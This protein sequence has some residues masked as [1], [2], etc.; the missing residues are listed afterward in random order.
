MKTRTFT[1]FMIVSLF[2]FAK[3]VAENTATTYRVTIGYDHP[4]LY[5]CPN[6]ILT[7]TCNF[8]PGLNHNPTCE[9][10]VMNGKFEDGTTKKIGTNLFKV[11]VIWSD[12]SEAVGTIKVKVVS[13][14]GENTIYNHDAKEGSRKDFWIVS[15]KGKI[16]GLIA[17]NIP[18]GDKSS[19]RFEVSPEMEYKHIRD[20]ENPSQV[21]DKKVNE[22]EWTLPN[23]WKT[24]LNRTGTF[25]VKGGDA[26]ID[27]I[28]STFSGGTV[29]VRALN[30]C[31][32]SHS[33][34]AEKNYQRKLSFV[35]Y[36]SKIP[37]GDAS[38]HTFEAQSVSGAEYEW[39]AP[40][41]WSINGGGATLRTNSSSVQV[42]AL[43]LVDET[44]K[45]RLRKDGEVSD[46]FTFPGGRI[47]LPQIVCNATDIYQYEPL[48]VGL[49]PSTI[50]NADI[51]WSADGYIISGQKSSQIQVAPTVLTLNVSADIKVP[52]YSST[53]RIT[54]SI[55]IKP[56]R[57]SI[58]SEADEFGNGTCKIVNRSEGVNVRWEF[59]NS[60]YM[61]ASANNDSAKVVPCR[62]NSSST[63]K[64]T[65]Y[66][67]WMDL[68][69]T[70]EF[71]SAPLELKGD[72]Y[73]LRVAK[74]YEVNYIPYNAILT[75]SRSSGMAIVDQGSNY[76]YMKFTYEMPTVPE[77]SWIKAS[78]NSGGIVTEAV[79]NMVNAPMAD[80]SLVLVDNNSTRFMYKA[81]YRPASIPYKELS[82]YWSVVGNNVELETQGLRGAV[83]DSVVRACKKIKNGNQR[84]PGVDLEGGFGYS[85]LSSPIVIE[86]D[87]HDLPYRFEPNYGYIQLNGATSL[88]AIICAV[89][90]QDG[91]IITK[92]ASIPL[93]RTSTYQVA[94]NPV[95]NILTIRNNDA[96]E[97]GMRTSF[98]VETLTIILYNDYGIMKTLHVD[99]S[100]DD[101][102]MDTSTVPNGMYYLNVMKN[103]EVIDRQIVIVKH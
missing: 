64:A 63:L 40:S 59:L 18:F 99:S 24:N 14:V 84:P 12:L 74:R 33:E 41:G 25:I 78:V 77:T 90:D 75:W 11:N 13:R 56:H 42:K 38:P 70:T 9:W 50:S 31:G 37:F 91:N 82:F 96:L 83:P 100:Q 3:T 45:V 4:K 55:S 102:Q 48:T 72:T 80:F 67:A 69:F 32:T 6:E 36:P 15:L 85:L 26:Y 44:V 95:N 10:E 27:V 54:K 81:E 60:N 66:S 52:T 97:S 5:T 51:T 8:N 79:I 39:S 46:W 57:I 103:G 93:P 76:V 34:Y 49:N 20:D 16:P 7:Y 21:S 23:G 62:Y 73:L 61:V 19:N 53:C 98:A 28:P 30:M 1:V 89:V 71:T 17:N 43:S 35:K 47:E 88:A 94:P 86:G 29:R 22:Y 101:I 68:P 92:R 2:V 65:L 58:T 87:N